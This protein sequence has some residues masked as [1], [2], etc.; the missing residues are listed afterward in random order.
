M[1]RTSPLPILAACIRTSLLGAL[2]AIANE[3]SA[4]RAGSSLKLLAA[5]TVGEAAEA[6]VEAAEAVVEAAEAVVEAAEAVVE[7]AETTP[8]NINITIFFKIF[9]T[10]FNPLNNDGFMKLFYRCKSKPQ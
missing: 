1:P 6:V 2:S 4:F 9:F 8:T 3:L 10:L 5:K 7:A